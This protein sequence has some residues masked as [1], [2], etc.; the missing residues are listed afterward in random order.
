MTWNPVTGCL[1]DCP[2]CYARKIANR[3]NKEG[4][5]PTFHKNRL[6]QPLVVKKPQNIFVCSMADLFGDW[7]PDHWIKSVFEACEAAPQHN[8]IF[9]TKNPI[10]Y[11]N[12]LYSSEIEIPLKPNFWFGTS[13]TTAE[14]LFYN[15]QYINTFASIEPILDVWPLEA[16][17]MLSDA[18]DWVIIGAETGNR[19]EKITPKKEWIITIKEQCNK[20]GK[21]IFMKESLRELMG[22]DF[23]QELPE[24]L[25]KS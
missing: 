6:L 10:R 18:A 3:F 24:K 22:E 21:P 2:Y 16:V 4:F 11:S 5:E 25:R 1:N 23:I 17:T 7:V 12:L 9:L 15:S 20:T 19:K 14:A 8:Y 13:M